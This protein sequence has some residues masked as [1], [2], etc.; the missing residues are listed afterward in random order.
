MLDS[1][2]DNVISLYYVIQSYKAQQVINK[3]RVSFTRR[4]TLDPQTLVRE[5]MINEM[6]L[7]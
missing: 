2:N 3:Y 1:D 4:F 7:S 6:L 5:A